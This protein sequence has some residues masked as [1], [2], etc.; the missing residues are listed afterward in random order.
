MCYEANNTLNAGNFNVLGN[1]SIEIEFSANMTADH[2]LSYD[3]TTI[4]YSMPCKRKGNEKY[5]CARCK[6]RAE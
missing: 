3:T 4:N 1:T 2:A 5:D 6:Q